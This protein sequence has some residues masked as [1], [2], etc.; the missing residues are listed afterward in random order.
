VRDGSRLPPAGRVVLP[1]AILLVLLWGGAG[2][3]PG[4][5]GA[6]PP[7]PAVRAAPT[8]HSG[9]LGRRLH[10]VQPAARQAQRGRRG[11][12]PVAAPAAAL[13][14]AL[15]GM[16]WRQRAVRSRRRDVGSSSCARAPP[17]GLPR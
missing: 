7:R 1:L 14:G 4:T 11:P 15:A 5:A 2:G 10:L 8:L 3:V 16:T 9:V 17:S 13:A 12:A 6:P